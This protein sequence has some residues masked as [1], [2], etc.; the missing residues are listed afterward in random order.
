MN[1]QDS[2][3]W[4]MVSKSKYLVISVN[5]E[6]PFLDQQTNHLILFYNNANN[7]AS[8][9]PLFRAVDK[10]VHFISENSVNIKSDQSEKTSYFSSP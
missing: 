10:Y 2:F 4:E 1:K 5:R 8:F 3:Y 6:F 9:F 7:A